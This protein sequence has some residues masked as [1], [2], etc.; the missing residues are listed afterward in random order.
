MQINYCC[1]HWGSEHLPPLEFLEKVQREGYSGI[2]INLSP[3]NLPDANF[4]A[5]L[6]QLRTHNNFTF[7]AQL[8]LDPTDE[9]P[10]QHTNRMKE[11]LEFL[12]DFKPDFIN[13]HT[14]R[15]F[16]CF[17][18]NCRI[19]DEA[20]NLSAKW[21]IPICHETHRGRFSFHLATLL[22]YLEKFPS[23]QLTG[24]FSH[25]CTV[26]ESMLQDQADKLERVIPHVSHIHARIG[27]E[28]SA[29]VNHPFA[30]EWNT[31]L[32]VFLNWWKA[33]V[34]HRIEKGSRV[35]TITPEAGPTPYM[36]L[37]PF[38]LKPLSDQWEVNVSMKDYLG[39]ELGSREG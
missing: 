21:S 22:P 12:M 8:V 36:P 19:I 15:D 29:Q 30:P 20:E 1:T 34:A 6:Q 38:S 9:T 23:L 31:H 4:F 10:E 35:L 24:D 16:F 37:E 2:E 39:M 28:Q 27:S 7:I 25:W 32:A 3:E 33:I 11:R 14:G 13:A 26:S 18:E 17:V 5:R